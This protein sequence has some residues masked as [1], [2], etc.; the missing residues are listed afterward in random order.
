MLQARVLPTA[1]GQTEH[2]R[3]RR[4]DMIIGKDFVKA[5]RRG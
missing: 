1:V 5:A 4:S 3:I 2:E